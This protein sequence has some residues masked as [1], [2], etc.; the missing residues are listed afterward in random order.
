M[1]R[2]PI[3]DRADMNAEQARVY[4]KAKESNSPVGG[5]YY[6]YIRLQNLEAAQNLR[7]TLAADSKREH[8][9]V[10]L[11]VA[12]HWGAKYP[13]FAQVRASLAA[14]IEQSVIDA[15]NARKTPNLPDTRERTCFVVAGKLLASKGLSDASYAAAEKAMGLESL[16]ALVAATGAFSTTCMTANTFGIAIRR[17]PI[18]RRWQARPLCQFGSMPACLARRDSS[19]VY[20]C[21]RLPISAAVLP[22]GTMPTCSS[23]SAMSLSCSAV[24]ISFSSRATTGAGIPAGPMKPN[25]DGTVTSPGRASFTRRQVRPLLGALVVEHAEQ[26][27]LAAWQRGEALPGE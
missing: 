5:P 12:R 7:G 4:D 20:L 10:N 13:W 2:I 11:T 14:G 25:H 17:R 3:I 19:S 6:A 24:R 23:L 26:L 1:P 16:V 22:T 8:Q 21:I 15:I 18:R 27:D 9:V